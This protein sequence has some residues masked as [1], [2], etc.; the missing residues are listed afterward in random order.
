M[1]SNDKNL[2]VDVLLA[3]SESVRELANGVETED[4]TDDENIRAASSTCFDIVNVMNCLGTELA[5]S[6][7]EAIKIE[8]ERK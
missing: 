1:Q 2:L 7:S 8:E 5:E 6:M 3:I 4:M